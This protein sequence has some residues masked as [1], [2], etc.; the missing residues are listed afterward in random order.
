MKSMKSMMRGAATMLAAMAITVS[1][2]GQ[3]LNGSVAVVPIQGGGY[4]V[5]QPPLPML[6]TWS[7][8]Q[9]D[10]SVEIASLQNQLWRLRMELEDAR[11]NVK[12]AI[13]QGTGWVTAN[14]RVMTIMRHINWC[15]HHIIALLN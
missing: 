2:N 3:A 12:V 10:N 1:A 6:G 4:V 8:P 15:E 11:A 14:M 7:M 13:V 9:R 5:V